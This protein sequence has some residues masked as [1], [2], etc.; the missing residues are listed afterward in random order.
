[1]GSRRKQGTFYTGTLSD[2]HIP[3]A[4]TPYFLPVYPTYFLL[5]S[6]PILHTKFVLYTFDVACC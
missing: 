6:D 4:I 5:V 2:M 1:M 3:I